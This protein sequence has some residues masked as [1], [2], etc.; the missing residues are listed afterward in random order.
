MLM[1]KIKMKSIVSEEKEPMY[2]HYA[3]YQKGPMTM[4]VVDP[5]SYT[6]TFKKY[7]GKT[8][9]METSKITSQGEGK[10]VGYE[11][12]CKICWAGNEGN[13]GERR[14]GGRNCMKHLDGW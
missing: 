2:F 10:V 13:R 12:D 9:K 1:M 8:G 3:S 11:H 7:I 5:A 4:V 6:N 14:D